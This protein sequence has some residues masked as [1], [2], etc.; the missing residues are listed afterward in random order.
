ME[1]IIRDKIINPLTANFSRRGNVFIKINYIN[2]KLSISGVEAP[3]SS[4]NCLGGCGQIYQSLDKYDEPKLKEDWTPEM[5]SK[6]INIW[7][8]WHLNDLQAGCEHQRALGWDIDGYDKHPSEPCPTCG[9]KY[10]TSWKKK[11]VPSDVITWL[12]KLPETKI[13]PSWV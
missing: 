11:D 2:G 8:N 4:G 13:K 12:E 1:Q 6:L 5:Y 10:G 3:L 9:Y 7:E